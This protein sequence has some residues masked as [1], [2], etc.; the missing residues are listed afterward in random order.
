MSI[1]LIL[2]LSISTSL[3]TSFLMMRF[4]MLMIEKW[5]DRFFEEEEQR[6][7]RFIQHKY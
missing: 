3:L 7:K 4:Q 1:L 2:I 5:M 6:M